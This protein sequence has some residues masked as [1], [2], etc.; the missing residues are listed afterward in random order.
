MVGV[1]MRQQDGGRRQLLA[2][3][4][5]DDPIRVQARVENQALLAARVVSHVTVFVKR[6]RYDGG[7]LEVVGDHGNCSSAK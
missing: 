4:K 6:G 1:P 7:Q 3:K 5:G 2:G